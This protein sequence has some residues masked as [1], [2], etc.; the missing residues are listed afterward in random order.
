MSPTQKWYRRHP[1]KAKEVY[2][3]ANKKAYAKLTQT[4]KY[5][6][7]EAERLRWAEIPLEKRKARRLKTNYNLDYDE[8]KS[9]LVKQNSRCLLC[10]IEIHIDIEKNRH[11]KACV[12]HDHK[13]GKIRGLLCNHCNRA[14][15]LIKDNIEVL[16]RMIKYLGYTP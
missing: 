7:K 6:K 10:E 3:R 15:G 14:L 9:M 16:N 13:T 4:E 2:T 11:D 5:K 8:Y 1:E 12:D